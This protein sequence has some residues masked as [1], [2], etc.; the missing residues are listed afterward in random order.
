MMNKMILDFEGNKI[1][2]IEEFTLSLKNFTRLEN[3]ELNL[4]NN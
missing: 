3:I 1:E 4:N 2:K